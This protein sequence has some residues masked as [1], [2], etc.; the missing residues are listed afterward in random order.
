MQDLLEVRVQCTHEALPFSPAYSVFAVFIATIAALS[1][2]LL[3]QQE[4]APA[5]LAPP[6]SAG[7]KRS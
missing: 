3:T 6:P 7:S 2:P 4:D 5:V 1:V